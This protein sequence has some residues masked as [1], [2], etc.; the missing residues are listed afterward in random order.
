[1]VTSLSAGS[2]SPELFEVCSESSR[3]SFFCRH[4]RSCSY[5]SCLCWCGSLRSRNHQCCQCRG[6]VPCPMDSPLLKMFKVYHEAEILS[7]V[8]VKKAQ[9]RQT[10]QKPGS[11]I[12]N[13]NK[14]RP[15]MQTWHACMQREGR[16]R[17]GASAPR[18]ERSPG[19][20]LTFFLPCNTI[21]ARTGEICTDLTETAEEGR[22][23]ADG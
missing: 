22:C 15:G 11:E 8:F 6:T 18:E 20:G 13:F 4:L 5:V 19:R 10:A 12:V 16:N 9:Y 1:M 2:A 14:K 3:T 21:A 23:P 7:M 17:R